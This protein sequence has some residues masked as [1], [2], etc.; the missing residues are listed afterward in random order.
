[1]RGEEDRLLWG[2]GE[3][4][5]ESPAPGSPGRLAPQEQPGCPGPSSG[6]SSMGPPRRGPDVAASARKPRWEARGLQGASTLGDFLQ[7]LPLSSPRPD[8][9]RPPVSRAGWGAGTATSEEARREDR[10]RG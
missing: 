4:Q 2:G 8:S 5:G 3:E 9:L 6:R 7:L 10:R 1:M